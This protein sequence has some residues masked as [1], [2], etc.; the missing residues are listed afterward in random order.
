MEKEKGMYPPATPEMS[1]NRASLAPGTAEAFR[2]F[3]KE[4][5]KAGALDEKTKQ[6]IAVAAAHITQCPYC[7]RSHTAQALKKGASQQEIIEAVWIAAEMRAGG[8][9]AHSKLALDEM[10]LSEK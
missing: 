3:S 6:L 9:I 4:V 8:A 7:I 5:F 1:K 10:E 2:N